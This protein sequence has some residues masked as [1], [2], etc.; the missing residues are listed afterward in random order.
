M[1]TSPS[2]FAGKQLHLEFNFPIESARMPPASWGDGRR[3]LARTGTMETGMFIDPE[4]FVIKSDCWRCGSSLETLHECQDL[5]FD[6]LVESQHYVWS[7][8]HPA[9]CDS[10]AHQPTF[11]GAVGPGIAFTFELG[12]RALR[13]G[14]RGGLIAALGS[15]GEWMIASLDDICDTADIEG[16]RRM[17]AG[18]NAALRRALFDKG[19]S[20]VAA[21]AMCIFPP[22]IGPSGREPE[23]LV[24]Q[25]SSKELSVEVELR[26]DALAD[27][28]PGSLPEPVWKPVEMG[29]IAGLLAEPMGPAASCS[30]RVSQDEG[31]LSGTHPY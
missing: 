11:R 29:L 5:G 23:T 28:A 16:T 22:F 19:D 6:R 27:L 2:P 25:A 13:D 24:V 9:A 20:A 31:A 10:V 7:K 3:G 30:S 26:A 8:S 1:R 14:V 21:V 17:L 12:V 18:R 15:S 4:G